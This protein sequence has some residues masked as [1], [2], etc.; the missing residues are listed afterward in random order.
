LLEALI[1]RK[2]R[3]IF[4]NG[5]H[6]PMAELFLYYDSHDCSKKLKMQISWG[7]A[8]K[9]ILWKEIVSEK[10]RKQSEFLFELGKNVNRSFFVN[11]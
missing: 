8:T 2:I 7:D 5:K 11:T 3:V 10:I 1:E 6:Y 4:C 9:K